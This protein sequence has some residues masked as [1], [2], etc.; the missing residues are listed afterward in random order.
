[1]VPTNAVV[2]TWSATVRRRMIRQLDLGFILKL[3]SVHFFE[4]WLSDIRE[5]ADKNDSKICFW[6]N[7]KMKQIERS[8]IRGPF[9]G[10]ESSLNLLL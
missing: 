4:D 9:S 5:K 2:V 1:M 6:K 3:D 7:Q 10:R 8:Q